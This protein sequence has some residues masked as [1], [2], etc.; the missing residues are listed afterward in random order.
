MSNGINF[1]MSKLIETRQ[2]N[3]QKIDSNQ[4]KMPEFEMQISG[5]GNDLNLSKTAEASYF[6]DKQSAL[7]EINLQKSVLD[8]L[9]VSE[10]NVSTLTND[11][12]GLSKTVKALQ[13]EVENNKKAG[14]GENT[15]YGHAKIKE[16]ENAQ[17]RLDEKTQALNDAIEQQ[18]I[19][20]ELKTKVQNAIEKAND[21]LNKSDDNI[22][23]E[24]E[25]QKVAQDNITNTENEKSSVEE[26]IKDLT[27]ENVELDNKIETL[28][29][30]QDTNNLKEA[31]QN[32]QKKFVEMPTVAQ[33]KETI[34]AF[35]NWASSVANNKNASE[36]EIREC[37][38]KM[39]YIAKNNKISAVQDLVGNSKNI[40]NQLKAR[41]NASN[42]NVA[43]DSVEKNTG[44]KTNTSKL[45]ETKKEVENKEVNQK[46]VKK[47]ENKEVKTPVENVSVKKDTGKTHQLEN[48]TENKVEKRPT[49]ENKSKAENKTTVEQK[50]PTKVEQNVNKKSVNKTEKQPEK[51]ENNVVYK[52][53]E[54][55]I[56]STLNY[57]VKLDDDGKYQMNMNAKNIRPDDEV[58]QV[59]TFMDD[60]KYSSGKTTTP[61]QRKNIAMT[62]IEANRIKMKKLI[63]EDIINKEAKG[64]KI[65]DGEAKFRDSFKSELSQKGFKYDDDTKKIIA[66]DP[67]MMEYLEER[68]LL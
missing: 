9:S 12:N 46:E 30:S 59:L 5:F 45:P 10:Q 64:E 39:D 55:G 42:A 52:D 21:L 54:T 44:D 15:S 28:K 3:Q 27:Q 48:K 53:A 32:A 34:S 20:E 13:N 24:Q 43:N 58:V 51:F 56:E 6:Q 67:K 37:I 8:D 17:K 66:S 65:S 68:G 38:D 40:S 41:L 26:E 7:D 57:T 61:P 2:K 35:N 50:Q 47:T 25:K 1:D 49:A 16:L 29:N 36:A 33:Q 19:N 11:V 23:N 4:L 14:V 31:A 63:Y 18:N 60:Y 22:K 62:S